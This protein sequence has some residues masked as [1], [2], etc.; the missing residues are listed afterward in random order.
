MPV[1]IRAEDEALWLDPEV[2][3]PER[4]QLLLVPYAESE[5]EAYAVST[6][7]NRAATDS[8]E[9]LRPMDEAPSS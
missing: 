4:L 9:I 2:I 1:I 5:M 6:A 8:E 3:E 7:I